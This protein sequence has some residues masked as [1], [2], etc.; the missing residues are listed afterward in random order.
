MQKEKADREL[1]AVQIRETQYKL[2][3]IDI[4]DALSRTEDAYNT[5]QKVERS[6]RNDTHN[7]PTGSAYKKRRKGLLYTRAHETHRESAT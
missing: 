2:K 7:K 1:A 3:Y 6:G 4:E 5:A